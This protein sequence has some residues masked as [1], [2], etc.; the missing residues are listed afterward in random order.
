M[1]PDVLCRW[2]GSG[3][4]DFDC[5]SPI[6]SGRDLKVSNGR[7]YDG[8]PTVFR[9]AVGPLGGLNLDYYVSVPIWKFSELFGALA[10][11]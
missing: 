5:I 11:S 8:S 4:A 10:V 9:S 7:C 3:H 2:K 1:V 6:R